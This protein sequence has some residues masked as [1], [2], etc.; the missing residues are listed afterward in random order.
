MA[1]FCVPHLYLPGGC[2]QV[3]VG[4][5]EG[6]LH[7]SMLTFSTASKISCAITATLCMPRSPDMAQSSAS[8]IALLVRDVRS[9]CPRLAVWGAGESQEGVRRVCDAVSQE[10]SRQQGGECAAALG[11]VATDVGPTLCVQHILWRSS[12]ELLQLF[13]SYTVDTFSVGMYDDKICHAA[14][15]KV[16]ALLQRRSMS[17]ATR[18]GGHISTL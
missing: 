18:S 1:P 7:T 10:L 9:S 17:G 2:G 16:A 13:R 15:H 5:R 11:T 6:V 14:I 4:T 12:A 3:A 8:S